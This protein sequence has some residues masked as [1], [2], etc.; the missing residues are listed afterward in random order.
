ME[1][2]FLEQGNRLA[3]WRSQVALKKDRIL[4]EKDLIFFCQ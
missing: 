3:V 4:A 1:E 2:I